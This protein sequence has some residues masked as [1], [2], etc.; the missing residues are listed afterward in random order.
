M[1]RSPAA[2]RQPTALAALVA[3][4][5]GLLAAV[6]IL[7]PPLRG[8]LLLAFVVTGPGS[9]VLLWTSLPHNLRLSVTPALGLATVLGATTIV[10]FAG[11]WSPITL[12][13]ILAALS[14]GSAVVGLLVQRSQEVD[15]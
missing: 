15:P 13:V 11:W 3:S 12:L 10:A 9:A 5:A 1:Y 7:P 6:P 2:H 8:V 4:V 14:G